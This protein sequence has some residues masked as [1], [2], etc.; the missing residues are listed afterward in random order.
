MEKPKWTVNKLLIAKNAP[1]RQIPASG[2]GFA[3]NVSNHLAK[4]TLPACCFPNGVSEGF[5]R[6]FEGFAKAWKIID[7]CRSHSPRL[8][9]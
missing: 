7:E 3:A 6:S 4:Q 1:V 2:G 5:G 8:A 9:L